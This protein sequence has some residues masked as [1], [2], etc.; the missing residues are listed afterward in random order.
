MLHFFSPLIFFFLA[1]QFEFVQNTFFP[2]IFCFVFILRVKLKIHLRLEIIRLFFFFFRLHWKYHQIRLV[3][4]FLKRNI[5]ANQISCIALELYGAQR[6][7]DQSVACF[8][9]IP[10]VC[11]TLDLK[12]FRNTYDPYNSVKKNLCSRCNCSPS[13]MARWRVIWVSVCVWTVSNIWWG[14]PPNWLIILFSYICLQARLRHCE[15]NEWNNCTRTRCPTNLYAETRVNVFSA[16]VALT[17]DAFSN[18]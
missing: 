5:L 14:N 4:L 12:S 7:F 15:E 16:N 13:N 1:Q 11:Q 17:I 3:F 8:V 2:S 18:Q 10:L 6:S 9:W